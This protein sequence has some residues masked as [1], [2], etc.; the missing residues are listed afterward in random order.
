MNIIKK[1]LIQILKNQICIMKTLDEV[2]IYVQHKT[3][4]ISKE[5]TRN[6]FGL[7]HETEILIENN[8]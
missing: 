2:R 5:N 6:S 1:L 8:E 7:E 4:N 3:G